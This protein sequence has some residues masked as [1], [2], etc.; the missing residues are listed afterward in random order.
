MINWLFTQ[1][2]LVFLTQ[3][4]WRD[5][6]FSYFLAKKNFFEI[7]FLSAKDFSPPLYYLILHFWMKIFGSSEIAL[8]LMSLIF[9]WLTTYIFFI[10]LT[11][12]LKLKVSKALF[13]LI[14][15]VINPLQLYYGFEARSYSMFSFLSIASFYFLFKNN[16]KMYL[17]STILGLYTHYFMIFVVA[18]QYFIFKSKNQVIAFLSFL[19]WLIF[20]LINKNF[21]NESFWIKKT[22]LKDI[23]NFI[24]NV[25]TGYEYDFKFFDKDLFKL[26]IFLLIIIASLIFIKLKTKKEELFLKTLI[27]W[28]VITPFLI[29]IISFIKPIFLPRYLIFANT[30]LLILLIYILE[31]YPKILKYIS[32]IIL[33]IIT[34]KYNQVQIQKR[35]KINLKKPILEIKSLMK[36]NDYLYVVS[37]LDF[38]TAQYYLD[39][40]RVYIWEKTYEEIP[41]YV[42]K[43]LIDKNKVK[44]LLPFYPQKAFILTPW[45]EYSIQAIY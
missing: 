44:N 18:I 43:V 9:F 7:I 35:Q 6:A 30:G 10:F 45:G 3:S 36:K 15:F 5:E 17:L 38:F 1:T 33:L 16:K 26:S 23:I 29:T 2:P 11:D 20:I 41:S 25:Y 40:N 32:I 27:I 24:G 28:S 39:E 34:I 37:E 4:F 12:I 19:P 42:G 31:K 13:Y 14:F 8:R 22:T 21:F